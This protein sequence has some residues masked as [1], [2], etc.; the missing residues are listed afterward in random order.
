MQSKTSNGLASLQSR[1]RWITQIHVVAG[2][3][4]ALHIRV[5]FKSQFGS[6]SDHSH[7]THGC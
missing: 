5:L 4:Q 3:N 1:F 2:E 7:A 6:S